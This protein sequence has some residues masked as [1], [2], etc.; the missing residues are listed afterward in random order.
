MPELPTIT[1]TPAQLTRL[2]AVFDGQTAPVTG[3]PVTPAESY[4]SWLA[5]QLVRHVLS[6][7]GVRLDRLAAVNRRQALDQLA[8]ELPRST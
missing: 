8:A 5:D 2:L 3:L 1:V 6:Q 7:E 4:K